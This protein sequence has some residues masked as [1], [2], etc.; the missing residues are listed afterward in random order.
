MSPALLLLWAAGPG[1][2]LARAQAVEGFAEL[3]VTGMT[4]LD[5]DVPLTV[6]ERFRPSFAA[7][8]SDRLVLNAT[9]EAG[10]SQGYRNTDAFADLIAYRDPHPS[11]LLA[12]AE[13][14]AANQLLAVSTAGDY[15]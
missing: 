2:G 4:G 11:L 12:L 13:D 14:P 9:I 15:L 10:L 3:L 7:P 5:A 1:L 8:L 6:V